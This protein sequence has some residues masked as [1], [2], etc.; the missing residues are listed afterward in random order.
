MVQTFDGIELQLAL[1]AKVEQ[2]RRLARR[3]SDPAVAERLLDL[4]DEY[5]Q[6][7]KSDQ[8][9]RLHVSSVVIDGKR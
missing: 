7:I 5:I 2:C 8:G 9:E 4:A 3:V 1:I 6:L